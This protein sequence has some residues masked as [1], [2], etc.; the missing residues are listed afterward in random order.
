MAQRAAAA[1]LLSLFLTACAP[2]APRAE[3]IT[4][5]AVLPLSGEFASL[6]RS[7]RD[8]MQLALDLA[9]PEGAWM[10]RGRAV[11]LVL[12][13]EDDRGEA[14]GAA[15]AVRRLAE[16]GVA[17]VIGGVQAEVALGAARAAERAGTVLLVPS[18]TDPAVTAGTS[19]VV[20]TCFD[21]RR[22]GEAM[23]LY[24]VR[25]LGA[26][27]AAIIFDRAAPYNAV[28]ARAFAQRFQ[29]LG[30]QVVA[31]RTFTDERATTD[32][33]S[34]LA[35]FLAL[36]PDVL[37]SP[38][39]YRATAAIA[40]QARE[41]GLRATILSGEGANSPDLPLLGGAAVEGAAYPVHFAPD[42]RAPEV[43]RFSQQFER[44]YGRAPDALA[45]LGYDALRL[46]LDALT[47]AGAPEPAAL[48]RALLDTGTF[49]GPTGALAFG[50]G[51]DPRKEVAIVRIRGGRAVFHA[52]VTP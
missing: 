24:A 44:A 52:R 43:T 29:A 15:S 50:G 35:P 45:A 46:L 7:M 36:R 20:R 13:V 14:S 40:V 39:Y 1:L 5:G 33:R 6:G 32:Y 25:V 51:S 16:A 42:E 26:R 34:L 11:R 31:E 47:R 2:R 37:F 48:R 23:A 38:N 9:A 41:V 30:G 21:D 49:T 27:R 19:T 28:L 18:A 22:A 3:T 8:G 17:A 10:L 12:R 4:V